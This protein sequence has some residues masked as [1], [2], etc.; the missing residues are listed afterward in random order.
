[1][2]IWLYPI[3][4]QD[5]TEH[6]QHLRRL[7]AR[8]DQYG[9]LVNPSKCVFAEKEVQFFGYTVNENGTKPLAEMVKAIQ[10]FPKL[11]TLKQLRRILGMLNLYRKLI[12]EP[13]RLRVSLNYLLKGSV[14]G[15]RVAWSEKV[16]LRSS[17][18]QK[19]I[20][21]FRR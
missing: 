3:A 7:F 11:A 20:K 12:A 1:M 9:M 4:S 5:E 18:Y 10:E 14:V 16:M 17:G 6:C 15:N 2:F 21:H 13:A 8:L 19:R